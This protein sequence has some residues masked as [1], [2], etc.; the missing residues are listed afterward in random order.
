MIGQRIGRSLLAM[1]Q[2]CVIVQVPQQ[3]L[4]SVA[5]PT[6]EKEEAKNKY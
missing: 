2:T 4:F 5:D 6:R 1:T 3:N